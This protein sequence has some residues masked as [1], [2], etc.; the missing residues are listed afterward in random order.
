LKPWDPPEEKLY[1]VLDD[2]LDD[3]QAEYK[4]P[5]SGLRVLGT[6]WSPAS[7]QLKDFLGR[8]QVPYQW[9]DVEIA[10][11][12]EEI[13]QL[14]PSGDLKSVSLPLVILRAAKCYRI[15]R[16]TNWPLG[17]GCARGPRRLSTTS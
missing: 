9:T 4:A 13:Q 12:D 2:L 14:I 17:S 8:N 6:R 3:W 1:P 10:A 5:Y 11:P 16:L 7:H 15:L